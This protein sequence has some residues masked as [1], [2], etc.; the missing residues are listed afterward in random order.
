MAPRVGEGASGF[1]E[2]PDAGGDPTA[3]AGRTDIRRKRFVDSAF[4]G[5]VRVV[6]EAGIH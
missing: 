6:S 5:G 3:E 4:S 1:A 2:D